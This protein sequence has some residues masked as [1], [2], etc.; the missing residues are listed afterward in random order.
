MEA[1]TMKRNYGS[2]AVY[3]SLAYDYNH[4]ESFWDEYTSAPRTRTE[5]QTKVR[6]RAKTVTHTKQ[7]IAPVSI[8]GVMI[9]A[10]LF[11]ISVM[12]QSKL[13]TI[14]SESVALQQ[15]LEQLEERKAKL[16]ISYESAF[17]M[18]DIEEYAVKSL[19]MQKPKADQIFY[20]DTSATDRAVVIAQNVNKGFVDRVSDFIV[21]IVE[22]FT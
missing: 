19:G 4:A 14:S 20:I 15:E 2:N 13:V 1:S 3:G 8:L 21:G 10:F 22:C 11:V 18:A 12:A 7:S 17:N 5:T 9:A 16:E 6:T